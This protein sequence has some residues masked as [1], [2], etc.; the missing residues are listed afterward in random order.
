MKF[1][2]VSFLKYSIVLGFLLAFIPANHAL[3]GDEININNLVNYKWHLKAIKRNT[4]SDSI[5]TGRC[6]SIFL[7]FSL[8]Q[9][10]VS[11]SNCGIPIQEMKWLLADSTLLFITPTDTIFA[12]I[13]KINKQK[14]VLKFGIIMADSTDNSTKNALCYG[15]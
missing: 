4:R 13:K 15:N 14:L 11:I 3:Q 2:T 1:T 10:V 6:D 5:I 12:T 7:N 8:Q 9:N